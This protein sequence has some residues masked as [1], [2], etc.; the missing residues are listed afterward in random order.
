MLGLEQRRTTTWIWFTFRCW[1]A[2]DKSR[3]VSLTL[4]YT[5]E[6]N[7]VGL[8]L[9]KDK[10]QN[11]YKAI[12]CS[13]YKQW[14]RYSETEMLETDDCGWHFLMTSHIRITINNC[15]FSLKAWEVSSKS[16]CT[17]THLRETPG[18]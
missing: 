12:S 10:A 5:C 9:S 8:K 7:C 14:C 4:D 13:K 16:V 17:E 1:R 15:T 2:T 3:S 6:G 11:S 18:K